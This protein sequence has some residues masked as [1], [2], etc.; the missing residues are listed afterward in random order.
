MEHISVL[1]SFYFQG[2]YSLG[3]ATTCTACPAGSECPTTTNAPNACKD[4]SFSVGRQMVSMFKL[5]PSQLFSSK[6]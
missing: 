4:G 6:T 1:V 5:Y 2:S 3:K